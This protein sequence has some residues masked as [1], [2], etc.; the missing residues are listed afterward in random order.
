MA[1]ELSALAAGLPMAASFAMAGGFVALREGRRRSSLNAAIHEL[2]RPLQALSLS[3]PTGSV[4]GAGVESSLQMAVAAVERLDRE[5]NGTGF[6]TVPQPILVKPLVEAAIERWRPVVA[7]AGRSL[8]LSWS[9][10][11]AEL[12]GSPVDLAQAVDNLISNALCHGSGPITV[13]VDVGRRKLGLVVCD[14]GGAA[15]TGNR[16][17]LRLHKRFGGRRRHGH[18]LGIVRRAAVQHG[19]EFRL[20]KSG[21]GSEARLDLPLEGRNR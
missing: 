13:N 1:I 10:R 3:L 14:R 16:D 12:S 9:G 17:L 11:E 20:R 18:G 4:T 7:L 5:I 8:Q 2:R 21:S 15:A 6:S 19:G